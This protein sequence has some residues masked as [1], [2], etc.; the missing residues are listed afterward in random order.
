MNT[1]TYSYTLERSSVDIGISHK[2]PCVRCAAVLSAL[3][4]VWVLM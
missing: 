1:Y 2:T 3:A 4:Y